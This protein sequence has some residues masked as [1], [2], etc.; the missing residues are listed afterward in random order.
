MFVSQGYPPC[1]RAGRVRVGQTGKVT[2]FAKHLP[3]P[4]PPPPPVAN[5]ESSAPGV[6]PGTSAIDARLMIIGGVPN[7]GSAGIDDARWTGWEMSF[8][9]G[10]LAAQMDR[11]DDAYQRLNSG[12]AESGPAGEGAGAIDL[13]GLTHAMGVITDQVET[14]L[15]PE[16]VTDVFGPDRPVGDLQ[17]MLAI[18]TELGACYEALLAFA[19]NLRCGATEAYRVELLQAFADLATLPIEQFRGFV[20]SFAEAAENQTRALR[21]GTEQPVG[22]KLTL[23]LS[24]DPA[25]QAHLEALMHGVEADLTKAGLR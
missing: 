20:A 19:T 12:P 16:R 25:A 6:V 18:A 3:P 7:Q 8:F 23:E 24:V 13:D 1:N 15:S 4:P 14:I 21:A 10:A 2:L 5:G 11:C 17:P 9:A 22:I